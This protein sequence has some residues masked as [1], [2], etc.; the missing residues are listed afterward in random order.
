MANSSIDVASTRVIRRG[1]LIKSNAGC[2]AGFPLKLKCH[3][4]SAFRSGSVFSQFLWHVTCG[5]SFGIERM[6][7]KIKLLKLLQ[8]MHA[9]AEISRRHPAPRS[10]PL[11][12]LQ[13]RSHMAETSRPKRRLI[14]SVDLK[15]SLDMPHP[16]QINHVKP[17]SAG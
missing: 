17:D 11:L 7:T 15:D 8:E 4:K 14:V 5:S 3:V 6:A 13:L 1:K 2:Q 10:S 16:V 12:L 9:F